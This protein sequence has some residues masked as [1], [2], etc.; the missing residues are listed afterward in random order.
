MNAFGVNVN[1]LFFLIHLKEKCAFKGH[2]Y[3]S[4]KLFIYFIDLVF[5]DQ[6]LTEKADAVS[7]REYSIQQKYY[8]FVILVEF[9]STIHFFLF[10]ILFRQY[11]SL[12]ASRCFNIRIFLLCGALL[13]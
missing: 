5:N 11:P 6:Y 1:V 12:T 13:E 8:C 10:P 7:V 9:G 3:V 2:R 4:C